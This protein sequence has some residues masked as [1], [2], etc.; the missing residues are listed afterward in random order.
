MKIIQR[1][2]LPFLTLCSSLANVTLAR[3]TKIVRRIG[4]NFLDLCG[5]LS[6]ALSRRQH[7][8]IE[9][10]ALYS[11]EFTLGKGPRACLLIHGL[12]CGPIQM[13][14]L[15]EHLS[16]AGFT[17]RGILLPGHCSSPE[18]L[19]G[20]SWQDWEEKVER[21]Y[22]KLKGEY[23][24]VSVIGFSVGGLLA[25]RLGTKHALDKIISLGAPLFIIREYFPFKKLLFITEKLFSRIKTVR[26]KW[27]IQSGELSGFLRFPT[28]SHYP[29]TTIKAMGELIRI[30]KVDLERI[31]SPLLVVHSRKDMVAAPFSAFY[32]MHYAGSQDKR[33][34]W[35]NRSDHLMMFDKEKALLFHAVKE[36]MERD[37]KEGP[38]LGK[39]VPHLVA[40]GA[41]IA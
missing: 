25:L 39:V 23:R 30:T 1:I 21:E 18:A 3:G 10:L 38:S 32:I 27:F 19:E 8:V 28:V 40:E 17:T 29:I 12:G 13:K 37:T 26:K 34:V 20:V 14:E 11:E 22:M 35:L 7:P 5:S 16:L 31:K 4:L 6:T 2:S 24:S 36:F 41:P 9:D 15:A 33:L